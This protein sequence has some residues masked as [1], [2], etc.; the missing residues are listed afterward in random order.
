M[1]YREAREEDAERL[2]EMANEEVMQQNLSEATMRDLVQ[3]RSITVAEDEDESV[4]GYVSY[5][6]VEGAVVVQHVCVEPGHRDQDV[7]SE[8]IER[9]LEFAESEGLN[10][11]LAVERDSW[12]E[13]ADCL[14][15]FEHTA[16][17]SF[18]DDDLVIYER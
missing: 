3:D 17:A 11:R 13:E 8:L 5:R 4:V 14:E 1:N 10:T 12:L 7:A 2:V 15:N 9:P 18:G 16:D 6:V